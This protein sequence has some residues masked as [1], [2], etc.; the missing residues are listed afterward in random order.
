MGLKEA[1][2][3]IRSTIETQNPD[4]VDAEKNGL[5]C[6]HDASME[7]ERCGFLVG[8]A[9]TGLANN[10]TQIKTGGVLPS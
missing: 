2:P 7:I 4:I 9:Q 6:R 5:M 10:T 8:L 1:L 3:A